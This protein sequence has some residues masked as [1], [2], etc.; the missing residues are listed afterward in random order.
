MQIAS[1]NPNDYLL[2]NF[3]VEIVN[4]NI[5]QKWLNRKKGKE[6]NI[7]ESILVEEEGAL[8]RRGLVLGKK[9]PLKKKY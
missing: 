8:Q 5:Y 9:L 1:N 4:N 6:E 3:G 7:E 2:S